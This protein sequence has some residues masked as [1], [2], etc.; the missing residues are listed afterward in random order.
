[1][2]ACTERA[3]FEGSS[4]K[5]DRAQMVIEYLKQ[6]EEE[7]KMRKSKKMRKTHDPYVLAD[8]DSE[9]VQNRNSAKDQPLLLHPIE[10]PFKKEENFQIPKEPENKNVFGGKALVFG[11]GLASVLLANRPQNNEKPK[12]ETKTG[13]ET[14]NKEEIM[15]SVVEKEVVFSSQSEKTDQTPGKVQISSESLEIDK[16]PIGINLA[17]DVETKGRNHEKSPKASKDSHFFAMMD[18]DLRNNFS[19]TE[20]KLGLA[21]PLNVNVKAAMRESF[22]SLDLER[23]A[24]GVSV[25]PLRSVD[26]KIAPVMSENILPSRLSVNVETPPVDDHLSLRNVFR[27][28]EPLAEPSGNSMN[29]PFY[30]FIVVKDFVITGNAVRPLSPRIENKKIKFRKLQVEDLV[31]DDEEMKAGLILVKEN[32]LKITQPSADTNLKSIPTMNPDIDLSPSNFPNPNPSIEHPTSSQARVFKSPKSPKSSNSGNS[33]CK[34]LNLSSKS[35]SNSPRSRDSNQSSHKKGQGVFKSSDSE[36]FEAK[37]PKTKGKA[38]TKKLQKKLKS[39]KDPSNPTKSSEPN[40]SNSKQPSSNTLS[41]ISIPLEQ[42][43]IP[44]LE[45]KPGK[46][47]T[48]PID[49]DLKTFSLESSPD[50]LYLKQIEQESSETNKDLIKNEDKLEEESQGFVIAGQEPKLQKKIIGFGLGLI[51]DSVLDKYY[52]E[53]ELR[54]SEVSRAEQDLESTERLLSK[55][56]SK[57]SAFHDRIQESEKSSSSDSESSSK[58]NYQIKDP[59]YE[60]HD[61]EISNI[62]APDYTS[63][64]NKADNFDFSPKHG[65]AAGIGKFSK[66]QLRS[67]RKNLGIK[68]KSEDESKSSSFEEEKIPND[69]NFEIN[70]E[71]DRFNARDLEEKDLQMSENPDSQTVEDIEVENVIFSLNSDTG[72]EGKLESGTFSKDKP[73]KREILREKLFTSPDNLVSTPDVE[74]FN[75]NPVSISPDAVK[76]PTTDLDRRSF[77]PEYSSPVYRVGGSDDELEYHNIHEVSYE[78]PIRADSPVI[79]IRSPESSLFESARNSIPQ[80]NI[81]NIP[82]QNESIQGRESYNIPDLRASLNNSGIFFKRN[83]L[84]LLRRSPRKLAPDLYKKNIQGRLTAEEELSQLELK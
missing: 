65:K 62:P 68:E 82:S 76:L 32:L 4:I 74:I 29:L 41:S 25:S 54:L 12:E 26:L 83:K 11:K 39:S 46:L 49:Q 55:K 43:S 9:V 38:L 50:D 80:I 34:K 81:F 79:Y 84:H 72:D 78:S 19:Q 10:K 31:K 33:S 66:K 67:N 27:R 53:S 70:I 23:Q 14:E 60:N 7:I 5:E 17:E 59:I 57:I 64:Y 40:P 71:N 13:E 44:H 61:F 37:Q 16:S 21:S 6:Q 18:S 2:G 58:K 56:S 73:K 47:N 3:S 30:P 52:E 24:F 22:G 75:I 63:D 1:M 69:E 8:S 28:N 48:N 15:N 42:D 51:H 35:N 77:S 20:I 36:S 45:S